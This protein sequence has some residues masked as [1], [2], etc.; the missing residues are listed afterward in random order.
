MAFTPQAGSAGRI[1]LGSSSNGVAGI[2]EW[3]ITSAGEVYKV[4]NFETTADTVTGTLG[5]DK[6]GSNIVDYKAT[7]T[8]WYDTDTTNTDLTFPILTTIVVDFLYTKSGTL[9]FHNKNCIIANFAR[10]PKLRE[11]QSFTLELE[12]SGNLGSPSAS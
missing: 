11:A 6:I 9:G 4:T 8:G 3:K 5:E 12:I 2:T 1:R 7:L 10:G